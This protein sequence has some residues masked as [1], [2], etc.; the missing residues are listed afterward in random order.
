METD[1]EGSCRLC[2]KLA[3]ELVHTDDSQ[4][5]YVTRDMSGFALRDCSGLMWKRD[6]ETGKA[7]A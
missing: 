6:R 5:F 1:Y 2:S 7:T 4:A 3:L